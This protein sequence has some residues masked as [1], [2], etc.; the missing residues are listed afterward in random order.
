MLQRVMVA[1]LLYALIMERT[2]TLCSVKM[3]AI[4]GIEAHISII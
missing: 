3:A 4:N 1:K 2:C